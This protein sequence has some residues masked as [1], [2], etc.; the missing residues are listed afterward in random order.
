MSRDWDECGVN[1]SYDFIMTKTADLSRRC[2]NVLINAHILAGF[3]V[4]IG[5]YVIN[6]VKNVNGEVGRE[7]PVKMKF[8]F[9]V[10]KSPL[11][12]C[13]LI[14]QFLYQLSLAAVVGMINALLATLV[15]TRR[16]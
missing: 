6:S 3:S 8:H 1:A 15:S 4:S 16:F 11:F 12:E 9:V 7:L 13:I 5:F 14:V 10:E 2:A